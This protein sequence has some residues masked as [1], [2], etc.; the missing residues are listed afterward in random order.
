MESFGAK[1]L[2]A[3]YARGVF[4]MADAR[5]DARI[6]LIDPE[7][8]GVLP[9]AG[10]HVSR[11]LARTVRAETFEVRIDTAFHDVVLACAAPGEGRLE[12]WINRP[13]ERLYLQLH[14]MGFAHSVECWRDGE[15]AGGLYGVALKGAF[16]GESMFSRARDASKVA[17]V[18]LVGRLIVGGFRLLDA[19]F[20]T[21]HLA[22]FGAA[23]IGR[24]EYHKRLQAALAVDADFQRAGAAGAAGAGAG[25]SFLQVISQAS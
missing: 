1:D 10:F 21:G 12:T 25:A 11:R 8:R 24:R 7:K 13:I 3:C 23:E 17:L 18:H 6:F 5:E 20:L 4:P 14:A 22:Q 16:F 2:L 19:Q 15:L 9:L